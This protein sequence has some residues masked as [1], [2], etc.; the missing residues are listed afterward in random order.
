MAATSDTPEGVSAILAAQDE[1]G[2]WPEEVSQLDPYSPFTAPPM[3]AQG[4]TTGGYVARM[5][6]MLAYLRK[7]P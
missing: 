5:Y 1:K 4:Y 7:S 3:Q 2:G 6:R